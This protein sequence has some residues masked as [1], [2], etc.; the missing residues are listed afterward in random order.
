VHVR[1]RDGR[2]AS[3]EVVVPGGILDVALGASAQAA[4]RS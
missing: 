4:K 3:A 2:E 1:G